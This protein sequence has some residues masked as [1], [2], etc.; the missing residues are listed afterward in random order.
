[1]TT[2]KLLIP[3][4]GPTAIGK[5]KS[6]IALAKYFDTEI[7]SADSRQFYKEM[8]I[9]TAVPSEEELAAIPHHFIQ[10]KSIFDSYSVGDYEREAL[11]KLNTLFDKKDVVVLAG[12]SGLYIDAVTRGLDSFP[13]IDPKI[14]K[15]L[16]VRFEKE[17]IEELQRQ[18]E[19]LDPDYF[20]KVDKH[21]PQRLIRALEVCLGTGRPY[22]S[23]LNKKKAQRP[24]DTITIGLSADRPL[25]YERIN[26]RVDSMVKKG[27]IE[28]VKG[29][30]EHRDLNALQTVG[31]SELFRFFDGEWDLEF[32]ISEIKKNTRRFAKRQ[33]TWFRKREDIVWMDYQDDISTVLSHIEKIREGNEK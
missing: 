26:Q 29:L 14:R 8:K 13:K 33:L 11:N 15:D 10:H 3:V 9:G 28:E 18:L 1:V 16:N 32:A 27:L 31:Y 23:F 17:G 22:S 6:G 5:T 19:K 24:F 4:V 7:I 30:Y 2:S 21:N 12:G 20:L 25:I